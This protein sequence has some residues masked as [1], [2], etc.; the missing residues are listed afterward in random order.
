[1]A[2]LMGKKKSDLVEMLD[3]RDVTIAELHVQV[4]DRDA[5]LAEFFVGHEDEIVRT[6]E[7]EV[8]K[9]PR[10]LAFAALMAGFVAALCVFS[11]TR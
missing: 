4:A 8:V 5:R 3:E 7:I 9:L 6:I 10:M 2:D 1:M 11:S